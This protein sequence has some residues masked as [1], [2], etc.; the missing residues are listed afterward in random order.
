MNI[1]RPDEFFDRARTEE[2]EHLQTHN[3]F[4]PKNHPPHPA[5]RMP[6]ESLDGFWNNMKIGYVDLLIGHR[7]ALARNESRGLRK[8]EYW[9][10]LYVTRIWEAFEAAF[11]RRIEDI[12]EEER[13]DEAW[14][15]EEPPDAAHEQKV[16]GVVSR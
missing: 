9:H 13:L 1:G 11:G 7:E 6:K 3:P 10:P 14:L 12:A 2:A 4:D 8:L 5:A 16:A 15:P